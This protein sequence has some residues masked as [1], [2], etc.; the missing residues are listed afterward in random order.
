M[1][2]E[3]M[4]R[5]GWKLASTTSGA[6]LNRIMEM[7]KELG[8]DAHLEEVTPEECGGCTLCYVDGGETIYRVYT[9]REEGTEQP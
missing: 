6:Q 3:K 7:Y 4:E 8:I 5:E 1:D 9:R 2:S